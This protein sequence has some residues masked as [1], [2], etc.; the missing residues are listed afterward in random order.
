MCKSVKKCI[1]GVLRKP[2]IQFLIQMGIIIDY[3]TNGI[4][5]LTESIYIKF[6]SSISKTFYSFDLLKKIVSYI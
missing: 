2:F 3:D 5:L 4:P 6:G 1:N